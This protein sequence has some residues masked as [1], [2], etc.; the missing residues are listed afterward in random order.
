[1]LKKKEPKPYKPVNKKA[2]RMGKGEFSYHVVSRKLH[3][4]FLQAHPDSN[5]S[6]QEFQ[7]L[8]IDITDTIRT[9]T[10]YNPLGVRLAYYLGE[11][12]V[13]YL[14]Y[15]FGTVDKKASEELGVE[16][17]NLHIH[18][19]GKDIKVKWERRWAVKF[20]RMLQFYAFE[21]DR[22]ICHLASKHTYES[23]EKLRVSRNTLGG[24]R[25]WRDKK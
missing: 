11:L 15:K 19:K 17:N 13:Q 22:K 10:V 21:P 8:W 12:K 5:I 20:N 23:P 18:S 9:E 24:K 14:P 3:E 4:K 6:W 1:M 16:V 2:P 7:K 25:A